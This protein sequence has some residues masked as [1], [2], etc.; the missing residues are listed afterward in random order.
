M[1]VVVW[2]AD[3][4]G[5]HKSGDQSLRTPYGWASQLCGALTEAEE[6]K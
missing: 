4:A 1:L 2:N 6:L 5:R 3:K